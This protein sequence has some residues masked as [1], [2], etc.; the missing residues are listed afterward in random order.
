MG[1]ISDTD[2]IFFRDQF[3]TSGI[4]APQQH[5]Q[6]FN[7]SARIS[8][9]GLETWTPTTFDQWTVHTFID[10]DFISGA[11]QT[12]SGGSNFFRLRS[13]PNQPGNTY[14]GARYLAA[15]LWFI[16]VGNLST[17]IEYLYG[18]RKDLD[19]QRGR[20]TGSTRCSSTTSEPR[21]AVDQYLPSGLAARAP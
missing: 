8:R 10:A 6:N 11:E 13:A 9:T 5:G 4:P 21:P 17:G 18:E 1:G 16:P 3:I 12:F 19:G 2:P 7:V 14:V 15:S 20:T